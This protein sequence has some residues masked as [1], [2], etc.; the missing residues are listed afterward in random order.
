M[1]VSCGDPDLRWVA[2]A[3]DSPGEGLVILVGPMG[4]GKTS[5]G[6]LLAER[7]GARFEDSDETLEALTG[8]SA[9]Q[10]AEGRGVDRLHRL[11]LEAFAEAVGRGAGVIAAA[12]SVVESPEARR[13][14]E[15]NT[16]VWLD[17]GESVLEGR[18][19]QGDHRRSLAPNEPEELAV[20]RRRLYA[21]VADLHVDTSHRSPEEVA[22][23]IAIRLS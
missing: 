16:T 21:E 14:L 9:A 3:T 15:A 2:M 12:A 5:V 19:L 4:A 7:I 17:A 11:E 20:R 1:T 8:E 6:R 22:T 23:E 13:L 18:R 10:I